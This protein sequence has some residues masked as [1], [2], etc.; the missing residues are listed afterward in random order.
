M[1]AQREEAFPI[2]CSE[3]GRHRRTGFLSQPCS[4]GSLGL[5]KPLEIRGNPRKKGL[6]ET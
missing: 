2:E 3:D 6:E 4:L 5:F 1:S